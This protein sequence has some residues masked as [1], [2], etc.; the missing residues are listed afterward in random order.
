[1][2]NKT[3]N[4]QLITD[5]TMTTES[6]SL[7]MRKG[8]STLLASKVLLIALLNI[9]N[10]DNKKYTLQERAYYKQLER[11]TNVDY[12]KGIVS[13]INTSDLKK[14]LNKKNSGSFILCFQS[15][16]EHSGFEC[17]F[18]LN[19]WSFWTFSKT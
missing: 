5:T 12:S 6:N 16:V 3:L 15:S 2:E 11:D 14:L 13:E 10:R 1:M 8:R 19:R 7:V 9:E 17:I 4:G 18:R